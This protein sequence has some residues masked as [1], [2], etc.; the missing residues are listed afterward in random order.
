MR[1]I[2]A[3]ASPRRKMLL[4]TLGIPFAVQASQA[5]EKV[6]QALP[7]E[8]V[9]RQLA[10]LK[11]QDVAGEVKDALVIGADTIV[12]LDGAVLGKPSSPQE[13]KDML[14][15]LS[16]RRH[17]VITGLALVDTI[18]GAIDLCHETTAVW[19]RRLEEEEIDWY[20]AT[21]EPLD[22]A[23]AYGIQGKGSILVE[24]IDGCYFNVVGLPLTRL[25]LML[26]AKGVKL[27]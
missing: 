10:L 22:K 14:R 3:S 17:E 12:V 13:A 9:A 27:S 2:L 20:V 24:R 4:E 25:Y 26:R 5:E 6:D 19:F 7:P 15:R 8:E 16:E 1:L 21:G 18:N 23:G 11:A